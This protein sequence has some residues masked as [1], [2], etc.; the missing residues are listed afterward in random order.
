MRLS[1]GSRVQGLVG[2]GTL[3]RCLRR[4]TSGRALGA[5]LATVLWLETACWMG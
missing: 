4:S 2:H 3:G 5:E 1:E